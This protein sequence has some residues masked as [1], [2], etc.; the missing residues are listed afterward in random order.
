MKKLILLIFTL[1]LIGS[2]SLKAQRNQ[3]SLSIKKQDSNKVKEKPQS[4]P[5]TV[6]VYFEINTDGKVQN[7]KAQKVKCKKCNKETI[8][9]YK[10]EAIKL[11]KLLRNGIL[12]TA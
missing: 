7:A 4:E 11:L 5:I 1:I 9:H 2:F 10:K 8:E 3:D 12:L 6:F